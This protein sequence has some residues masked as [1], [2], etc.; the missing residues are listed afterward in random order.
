M[1]VYIGMDISLQSTYVC[2]VKS[3]GTRPG[4]GQ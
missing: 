4:E 1:D 2:I 3:E